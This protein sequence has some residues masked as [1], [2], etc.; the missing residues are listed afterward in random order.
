MGQVSI[1]VNDHSYTLAC[2]DGEEDRL[3]ELASFVDDKVRDLTATLGQIGEA[4][5]FL[6]AALLVSDELRDLSEGKKTKSPILTK[7]EHERDEAV[8]LMEAAAEKI[9]KLA[10]EV[11]AG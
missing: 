7:A 1:T 2:R 10:A 4:R 3:H 11:G 5:L 6:M 9:E 8:A